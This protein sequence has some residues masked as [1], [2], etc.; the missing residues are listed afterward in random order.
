MSEGGGGDGA[1]PV[2]SAR[3]GALPACRHLCYTAGSPASLPAAMTAP[4][5]LRSDTVTRPTEGD[6]RRDGPQRRWATTSTARTRAPTACRRAHGRAAGQ[7]AA[8]WLPTGT[9]ANQVALRTL[10]RPG[11]KWWRVMSRTPPGTSSAV[12]RPMPGVQIHEIG[13]GGTFS[14]EQ[15]RA[16]VKPRHIPISPDDDAGRGREHPPAQTEVLRICGWR[17]TG[18]ATLSR[19]R[20]LWNA[21]VASGIAGLA[22]PFDL[23]AWWRSAGPGRA[24]RLAL[25]GSTATRTASLGGAMHRTGIF[26]ARRLHALDHHLPRGWSAITPTRASSPEPPRGAGAGA[27][28]LGDGANI[29]VVPPRARRR[30][31]GRRSRARARSAACSSTFATLRYAR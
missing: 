12:P 13:E 20:R 5:D 27:A 17:G 4:I 9:M 24:G 28:R 21:G 29:V 10:T 30:S 2:C 7:E 14:A 3:S 1:G 25:A 23:V 8:L 31:T 18:L 16:A 11:T 6:A 19:R 26:A 15:L 22:A